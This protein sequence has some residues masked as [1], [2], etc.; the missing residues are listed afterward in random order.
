M[1]RDIIIKNRSY[2]RFD[3]SVK[4]STSKLLS[5]VDLVRF[6]GSGRNAQ[7]L[8]YILSCDD[9]KNQKVF[10]TLSW[11]AYLDNWKGPSEGERPTAYVIQLLDKEISNNFFCDDGIA[12][13]TILLAAVEEG[14][15]GCIFRSINKPK[16]SELLNIPDRYEIINVISLGK[17]IE[18][19]VIDEIT[20]GN[21]KYWRDND[22]V[23]HVPKRSLKEI[24][25]EL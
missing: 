16:L 14:Y 25:L 1:I 20:N 4:I 23:H 19:V 18:K 3:E 24:V 11:A 13:Q 10:S 21:F 6:C 8:K 15:G 9:N 5:W 2:R 12:A 22:G 17:P 7:P